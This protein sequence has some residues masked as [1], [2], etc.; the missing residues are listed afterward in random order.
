MRENCQRTVTTPRINSA[1]W[2]LTLLSAA[3]C[4]SFASAEGWPKWRGPRGDGSWK[5]L[6]FST[7]WPEKLPIVWQS[8]IG[9]AYSGIAVANGRV[10]TLDRS[11]NVERVVCFDAA[12]GQR[13]WLHRYE[14]DYADLEYGKGP[15]CTPTVFDGRVYT[16]GSVGHVHCVDAATGKPVWSHDLVRDFKARQPTWGF[17]A[18][19]VVSDGCVIIHAGAEPDGC[20]IAFDLATGEERWR[21]GNDPAGYCTPILT[22]LG[23]RRLLI[24]WTPE[25][26]LVASPED[27]S[28]VTSVPYKVTMGVS[29]ATP[30]CREDTVFVS[31]YWEGTKA[32]RLGSNSAKILWE[33]NRFLRGLMS[34]PLYRQGH[35]YLLDK[36]HGIVCCV[37][38]TGK[39][40]WTDQNQLTPR[41]RN[42]QATLVWVGESEQAICLNSAG[43]L[44]LCQFTPAGFKE[45]ARSK[46]IGETWAHPAY[47]GRR[48]YARDDERI[49]CVE[50]PE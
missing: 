31:G 48:V 4:C 16:I 20:Y 30:I 7:T 41:G 21:F 24:G 17:A 37:L 36:Q 18:S 5:A 6:P 10:Y 12:S 32:I 8:E 3:A 38:E 13:L 44:V 15:R 2:T 47:V 9:P 45:L 27:G 46:I 34:Q 1:G 35:V 28:L 50:L 22:S 14:A 49:L 26:V 25:H 42:P 11:E 23:S 33:E 39:V 43:E 29:I 40:V 19:P